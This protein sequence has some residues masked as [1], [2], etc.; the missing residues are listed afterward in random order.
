MRLSPLAL[1]LAPGATQGDRAALFNSPAA[2]AARA[3]ALQ[4]FAARAEAIVPASWGGWIREAARWVGLRLSKRHPGRLA[5]VPPHMGRAKVS[6]A[7]VP[8]RRGP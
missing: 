6:P 8:A 4:D 1:V 2:G 7:R 5:T 3:A